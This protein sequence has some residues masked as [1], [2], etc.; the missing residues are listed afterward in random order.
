V[1]KPKTKAGVKAGFFYVVRERKHAEGT[2]RR[3]ENAETQ[4]E[5]KDAEGTQRCGENAKAQRENAKITN[6]KKATPCGMAL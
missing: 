4:G 2:Q 5:R 6:K 3:K 1:N